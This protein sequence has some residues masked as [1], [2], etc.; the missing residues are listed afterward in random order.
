MT[1]HHARLWVNLAEVLEELPFHGFLLPD[2]NASSLASWSRHVKHALH[3]LPDSLPDPMIQH[4]PVQQD[5][6]H[7]CHMIIH[8]RSRHHDS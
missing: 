1:D 5:G 6:K 7:M 4:T 3:V 8:Y 2:A